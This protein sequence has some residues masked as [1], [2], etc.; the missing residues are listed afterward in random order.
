MKIS[1]DLLN[2]LVL[3]SMGIAAVAW[4]A[5][6]IGMGF[7][8]RSVLYTLLTVVACA[9]FVFGFLNTI[10][11]DMYNSSSKRYLY[12]LSMGVGIVLAYWTFQKMHLVWAWAVLCVLQIIPLWLNRQSNIIKDRQMSAYMAAKYPSRADQILMATQATNMEE[13]ARALG[14]NYIPARPSTARRQVVSQFAANLTCQ[15]C[16]Q[17]HA[18]DEWPAN[19]DAIPFYFQKTPGRYSLKVTCPHCGKDWYVVWDQNPGLPAA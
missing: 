15:H 2:K 4:L 3:A 14:L 13:Y 8:S 10:S 19:G 16:S 6:V 9:V 7:L 17:R 12:W 11:W 5:A 18:A 1:E